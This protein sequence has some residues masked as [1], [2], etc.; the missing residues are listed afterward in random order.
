MSEI[1]IFITILSIGILELEV[2]RCSRIRVQANKLIEKELE[3]PDLIQLKR[4]YKG[5]HERNKGLNRRK[6]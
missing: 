6:R 5:H 4:M 2:Y 3:R 1:L